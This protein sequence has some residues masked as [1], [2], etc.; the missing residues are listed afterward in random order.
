MADLPGL[1]ELLKKGLLKKGNDPSGIY[2]L[3]NKL[4][5]HLYVGSSVQIYVRITKH[6]NDLKGNHHHSKHL[7]RAFNKYGIDNFTFIILEFVPNIDLLIREQFWIDNL[8]PEYNS[9]PTAQNMLGFQHSKETKTL[10]SQQKIEWFKNNVNPWLGRKA[11]EEHRENLRIAHLGIIPNP[12]SVKRGVEKRNALGIKPPPRPKGYKA[13]SATCEKISA[14]WTEERRIA[15]AKRLKENPINI[16]VPPQSQETKDK[17]RN[18]ALRLGLRPPIRPKG[19]KLSEQT[20]ANMKVSW[21]EERKAKHAE[22]MRKQWEN[23][24]EAA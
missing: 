17:H 14:S 22:R 19:E 9:R 23:K 13:S 10:I 11:T 15:Q 8:K 2:I 16:Y 24:K 3:V 18:T 20:I 6:F 7:Q 1:E 5:G 4:N 21:T 12:E